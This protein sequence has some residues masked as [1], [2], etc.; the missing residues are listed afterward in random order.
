MLGGICV[1][2]NDSGIGSSFIFFLSFFCLD[3]K[4][5]KKKKSSL[6]IKSYKTTARYA[7]ENEWE[8]LGMN[9]YDELIH[10]DLFY[11]HTCHV[12]QRC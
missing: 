12:S 7:S 9:R 1:F 6:Q 2:C 4:E 8:G 3:T 10:S 5:R 11:V